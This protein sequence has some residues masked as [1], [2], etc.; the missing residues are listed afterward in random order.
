MKSIINKLD[1]YKLLIISISIIYIVFGVLKIS[2]ESPIRNL[3]EASLPFMSNDNF[4]RLFGIIEVILGVGL[5]FKKFREY[6][7]IAILLHLLG[8]MAGIV[9]SPQILFGNGLI[10]TLEGEFVAKNI[11]LI[12]A[13]ILIIQNEF[14]KSGQEVK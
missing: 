13:I 7:A 10:P 6:F 8:T 3:V 12:S 9:L 11:I 2:L 4:F 14:R 5:L 1:T